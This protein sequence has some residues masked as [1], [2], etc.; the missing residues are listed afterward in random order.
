MNPVAVPSKGSGEAAAPAAYLGTLGK[1]L[2]V[3]VLL[4]DGPASATH[5]AKALAMERTGAYRILRTLE[6][7]GFV[8]RV[9]SNGEYRLG[10]RLWELGIRVFGERDLVS[11][12]G[13]FADALL[14]ATEETVH[15]CIYDAGSVVYVVK[16]DGTAAIGSYTRLGG[17]APAYCVATGKALLAYQDASEVERVIAAGL[18]KYTGRTIVSEEALRLELQSVRRNGYAV[19]L[20]EWRGEVGGVAAPILG[21]NGR[22][23]AA[24]G[25]SGP[26]D[27]FTARIREYSQLVMQAARQIAERHGGYGL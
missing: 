24:I 16:R 25:L 19:N 27:R 23:S 17:R 20:G 3:L 7:H 5:V 26:V 21:R 8:A 13:E 22:A 14:N 15:V 6:H 10:V 18:K 9:G 1:G 11:Q 2:R 4:Q 12:T